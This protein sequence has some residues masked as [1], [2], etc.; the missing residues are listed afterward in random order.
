MHCK[1]PLICP[2]LKYGQW[3]NLMSL[4]S[5]RGLIFGSKNILICNLLILSI[6]QIFLKT[7][8][9]NGTNK[10]RQAFTYSKSAKKHKSKMWNML[11]VNNKNTRNMFKVNDKVNNKDTAELHSGLFIVN[12]E[13]ILL[14]VIVFLL[15]TLNS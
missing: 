10:S 5:G 8:V 3:T 9:T 14:L 6:F 7:E 15:L 4:Y 12:F 13:H 1:N 11:K 2:G